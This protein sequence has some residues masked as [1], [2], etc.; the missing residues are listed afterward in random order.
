[1][2]LYNISVINIG[3][4]TLCC[5]YEFVSS[6][7]PQ[8]KLYSHHMNMMCMNLTVH[9]EFVRKGI[10]IPRG[11]QHSKKVD[12][13]GTLWFMLW[14]AWNIGMPFGLHCLLFLQCVDS[15]VGRNRTLMQSRHFGHRDSIN[16]QWGKTMDPGI[17]TL[18]V[19]VRLQNL[20]TSQAP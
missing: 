17:P 12:T 19:D 3:S 10:E 5:I 1:M 2:Y 18:K 13:S 14:W 20:Q 4:H 6:F 8:C 11:W 7:H 9:L 15:F 16:R